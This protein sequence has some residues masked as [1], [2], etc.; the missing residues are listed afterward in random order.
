MPDGEVRT[1]IEVQ[2]HHCRGGEVVIAW[3]L[4]YFVVPGR[5]SVPMPLP[6]SANSLLTCKPI[7]FTPASIPPTT[8]SLW[9][10]SLQCSWSP[11]TQTHQADRSRSRICGYQESR[12]KATA[13]V[14][15]PIPNRASPHPNEACSRADWPVR[16]V[17]E[18]DQT[19]VF[20]SSTRRF[21]RVH[22]ARHRH[23]RT[24]VL[25]STQSAELTRD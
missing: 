8:P 9:M 19:D 7:C 18:L 10:S 11:D 23:T 13:N 17:R 22:D 6:M 15:A 24:I 1:G 25:R 20:C 2:P 3:T 4:Y 12:P 14:N 16:A 21:C 5:R